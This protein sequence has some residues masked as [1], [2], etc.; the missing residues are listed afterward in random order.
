MDRVRLFADTIIPARFLQKELIWETPKGTK[1]YT[2]EN[3][4]KQCGPK[5]LVL[6]MRD[7]NHPEKNGILREY[8]NLQLLQ[9]SL[10]KYELR[11]SVPQ[12]LNFNSDTNCFAM[13]ALEGRSVQK[14]VYFRLITGVSGKRLLPIA[15]AIGEWI[16]RFQCTTKQTSQVNVSSE[17]HT[18]LS[19][20]GVC[21]GLSDNARKV[22]E[23]AIRDGIDCSGSTNA[24][25]CH[26]D[27]ALRNILMTEENRINVIDWEHMRTG[28]P[29]IDPVFMVSNILLSAR[30]LAKL[31]TAVKTTQTLLQSWHKCVRDFQISQD[32]IVGLVAAGLIRQ[33]LKIWKERNIIFRKRVFSYLVAVGLR[34]LRREWMC[35]CI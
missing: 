29:L 23:S 18:G 33:M 4:N 20:L 32:M 30:Y 10:G 7:K 8:Q 11:D 34:M 14:E 35:A 31:E 17:L 16:G 24:V 9:S 3:S 21:P 12:P 15:E 5:S 19:E 1:I 25:F 27:F 28:H 2:A 26:G 6:K 13:T 22:F